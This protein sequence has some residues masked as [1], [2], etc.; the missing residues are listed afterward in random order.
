MNRDG[1]GLTRCDSAY[2]ACFLVFSDR[3]DSGRDEETSRSLLFARVFSRLSTMQV[4]WLMEVSRGRSMKKMKFE[5]CFSSE[6][7]AHRTN[8]DWFRWNE[9]P[10]SSLLVIFQWSEGRGSTRNEEADSDNH[11]G[12][13]QENEASRWEMSS[14]DL[15]NG[16]IIEAERRRRG[17]EGE[18]M[19]GKN[20]VMWRPTKNGARLVAIIIFL[21]I[22]GT[23]VIVAGRSWFELTASDRWEKTRNE[24]TIASSS[25]FSSFLH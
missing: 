25:H 11:E 16:S 19:R 7:S 12:I 17:W 24:E 21:V 14:P 8:H 9:E 20:R 1:R 22:I 13:T 6:D 15:L 3:R 2:F 18:E 23:S 10:V 5:S 4:E